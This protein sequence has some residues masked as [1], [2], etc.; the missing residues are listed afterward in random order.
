[1]VNTEKFAAIP[2]EAREIPLET[3]D[4]PYKEVF[5]NYARHLLYGDALYASGSDGLR[6]CML[7]NAI[8]VSGWEE[9]RVAVPVA[10][11]RYETELKRRQELEKGRN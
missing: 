7:T 11:E 5:E 2:H 8:Y 1:M 6:T 3:G 4:N 10:P 9:R